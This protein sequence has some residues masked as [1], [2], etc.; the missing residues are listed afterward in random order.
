[1][2]FLTNI[3]PVD[4]PANRD[5]ADVVRLKDTRATDAVTGKK[6]TDRNRMD[7]FADKKLL[8]DIINKAVQNGIDPYTALAMAHQ[9]S[10]FGNEKGLESNP[11][12]LSLTNDGNISL[13]DLSEKGPVQ[14]F[15]EK[16]KEKQGLAKKLGKTD[17]A[18][19]IQAWNGYGKL[20]GK[21]YYGIDATKSP[22][23]MGKNPVYGKR[24]VDIRDNIIKANPQIVDMVN[25]A[26]KTN[27]PFDYSIPGAILQPLRFKNG[28]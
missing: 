13:N 9:E 8:G 18:A 22:I 4:V 7:T 2:A 24:V 17:D 27:K 19:I 28:R 14:V 5:M 20:G 12:H 11:F 25:Q 21:E 1:M 6:L 23:D 16:F 15:M 10:S 3:L 26:T